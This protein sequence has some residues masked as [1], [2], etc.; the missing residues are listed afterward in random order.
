[1]TVKDPKAARKL[2]KHL[3]LHL[4]LLKK[5]KSDCLLV[6]PHLLEHEHL[7]LLLSGLLNQNPS[8]SLCLSA[9]LLG[10][11]KLLIYKC[12]KYLSKHVRNC[13][14]SHCHWRRCLGP[15]VVAWCSCP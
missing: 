10:K 3:L 14:L 5:L 6:L 7:G 2:L 4:L 15:N 13:H 11:R 1:V 9:L 8:L 12:L